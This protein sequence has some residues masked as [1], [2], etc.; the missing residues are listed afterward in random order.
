MHDWRSCQNRAPSYLLYRNR[1]D[2]SFSCVPSPT[3]GAYARSCAWRAGLAA[4]RPQPPPPGAADPPPHH[5]PR[6]RGPAV[7]PP[8]CF[9]V[10]FFFVMG[11][12]RG[13]GAPPPTTAGLETGATFLA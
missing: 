3:A 8:V 6:G 4:G 2:F 12:G 1:A 11:G 7:F 9:F 10:W 13:G 5:P